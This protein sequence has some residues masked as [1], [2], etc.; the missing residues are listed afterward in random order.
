MTWVFG[1]CELDERRYML[2]RRGADQDLE[3]KVFEVLAYLIR[4]R[5]RVVPKRELLDELWPDRI[6]GEWSL[7]RCISM[8]RKAVGD[9]PSEQRVIQTLYG[10]GYRFVARTRERPEPSAPESNGADADGFEVEGQRLERDPFVGRSRELAELRA[11]LDSAL[12][13][14]GRVLLVTGETGIGKTR[15]VDELAAQAVERGAVLRAGHCWEAEGAPSFWPWV[16]IVRAEARERSPAALRALLGSGAAVIGQLVTE[17]AELFP[18]LPPPPQLEAREARFRMFDALTRFLTRAAIEH[19]LFLSLDDL[20]R[21]DPPSLRLLQ[22]VA[23]E[24]SGHPMLVVGTCREAELGRAAERARI[25]GELA[26]ETSAQRVHLEGLSRAAVGRLVH[27]TT[28]LALNERAITSL[29]RQTAGNPFFLR[30][31]IPILTE[32]DRSGERDLER[33]LPLPEGVRHAILRQLDGLSGPCRQLLDIACVVGQ[34]FSEQVVGLACG[35]APDGLGAALAEAQ[36]SRI[37]TRERE[38]SD[39][40]HFAHALV[41][42]TLYAD[43]DPTARARWHRVV[44]EALEQ[45]ADPEG[46]S[47]LAELAH[48]FSEAAPLGLQKKALDYSVSAGHRAVR[49]LAY[50]EGSSHY[51]RSLRLMEDVEPADEGLRCDLLVA[52]GSAQLRARDLDEARAA[53]DRAA[54]VAR[55]LGSAERLAEVAVAAA[56]GFIPFAE[57]VVDERVVALLEEAL[58]R[59]GERDS[60][61]RA[62]ALASLSLALYWSDAQE[63]RE[64]LC[65]ESLELARRLD[66]PAALIFT[67]SAS[68]ISTWGPDLVEERLALA[69]EAVELGE[70]AGISA[71]VLDARVLRIGYW[72]E[73]G[74][75]GEVDRELG[76][77]ARVA[78]ELRRPETAAYVPL[79]SASRAIMSGDFERGEQLADQFLAAVQQR[80]D[81]AGLMAFGIQFFMLR[82]LQGRVDEI[83]DLLKSLSER[84][85]ASPFFRCAL[86][87]V[88]CDLGRV[89]EALLEVEQLA[90]GGELHLARNIGWLSS[91]ALLAEVS[92]VVGDRRR[93]AALYAALAPYSRRHV[94]CGGL[95]YM[96]AAS[97]YLGQLATELG[98]VDIASRHF[99][100][101]LELQEKIAAG[102]AVAA[103]RADYARL[104]HV[105]ERPGDLAQAEQL[106]RLALA[107]AREYGMKTLQRRLAERA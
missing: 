62:R 55:E 85:H 4:Q 5:D 105:R 58:A 84:H 86:A 32:L 74:R 28:G 81:P 33:A 97:R 107:A 15:L 92:S 52:L 13:G 38:R 54:A 49:Q 36:A 1:E 43:L 46:D 89:D 100:V 14:R 76:E 22:F 31:L 93:C 57:G 44:G 56:F 18:D 72:F 9:T 29:H 17:V 8:A 42:D 104:L 45:V 6:V 88:Y 103:T 61:L 79:F 23:R 26:R 41:R 2:R 80:Q 78:P 30:Q 66:D 40:L 82:S 50:E 101:A 69:S 53:F 87:S 19:P 91:M 10:R 7:T 70:R 11:A 37:V 106:E 71:D 16:Q 12:G 68:L 95:S 90:P 75:F 48:H 60:P 98:R 64:Q 47:H 102:P 59:L 20:H 96:G 67:V 77:I 83:V 35:L 73:L 34:D 3:P 94:T 25:V 65:E 51:L 99:E 21:A 63:R 39:H 24:V 27:A